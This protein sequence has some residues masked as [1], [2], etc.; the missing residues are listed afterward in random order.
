MGKRGPKPKQLISETW[1]P[2]LAYAIGLLASDGCLSRQGHIDLSSAEREQLRN[3]IRCLDVPLRI[4]TKQGSTANRYWRVQFKNMLFYDFLVTIGL[5]PAK[6]KTIGPLAIPDE[7]FWDFL[8]GIFD[9]DG[10]TYSYWDKRWRSS[11]MYYVCFASASERF[12]T[13]LQETIERLEGV[14]GHVTCSTKKGSVLR[15]LKFAKAD[16]LR[17]LRRMYNTQQR[18]VFLKR[19]R[20]KI[21][22]MLRIVGERL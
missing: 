9:G 8:R 13:W 2:E 12:I 5:T 15:S 19:K 21:D 14:R 16:G 11:F 3:Y 17:V 10:C 1:R 18:P 20:L 4:E 22:K 7:L 6:S